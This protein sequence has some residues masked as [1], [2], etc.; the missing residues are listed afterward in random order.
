MTLE[1]ILYLDVYSFENKSQHEITVDSPPVSQ[2]STRLKCKF[3][4]F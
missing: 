3:D 2:T 1:D 4:L